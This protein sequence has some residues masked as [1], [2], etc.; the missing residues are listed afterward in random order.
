MYVVIKSIIYVLDS[1]RVSY[2][3]RFSVELP[4]NHVATRLQCYT[5]SG[6][7]SYESI[8]VNFNMLLSKDILQI[9]LSK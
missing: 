7:H 1:G 8:S 2:K 9:H 4:A 3:E 6:S 5:N